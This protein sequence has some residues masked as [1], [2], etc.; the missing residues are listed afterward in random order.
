MHRELN[1]PV[2]LWGM[3][4]SGKS[5]VGLL[6]AEN[7]GKTFVDLDEVIRQNEKS[8]IPELF[9]TRGE[10][11]FRKAELKALQG[12]LNLNNSVISCGGGT[13][14][15]FEN[16]LKM[17]NS[18]TT[19][20]LNVPVGILANRLF[21]KNTRP[22]LNDSSTQK[23]LI[24]KLTDLLNKR[25]KYYKE[26]KFIIEANTDPKTVAGQIADLIKISG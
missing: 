7:T 6:V 19:F 20:F 24:L 25:E 26:A 3:P 18:G 10:E 22:L 17:N 8:T 12:V 9:K 21:Q 4:G 14:V 15:F 2:F 5:T 13:P 16:Y 23:D 1:K 11:Y